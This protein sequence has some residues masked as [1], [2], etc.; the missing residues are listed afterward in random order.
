MTEERFLTTKQRERA[1]RNASIMADANKLRRDNPHL[2]DS[3][4]ARFL[5]PLYKVKPEVVRTV[6]R[7]YSTPIINS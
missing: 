6:L 7:K 5:A 4:L 1:A 2:N 3:Q